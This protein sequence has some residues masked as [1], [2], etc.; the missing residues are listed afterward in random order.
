M[1]K[2]SKILISCVA[3]LLVLSVGYA[4]FS[5]NITI[6]GTATAEGDFS[7]D[8]VAQIGV[9]SELDGEYVNGDGNPVDTSSYASSG[10][11]IESSINCTDNKVTYSGNFKYP[12]Q[13]QYFSVKLTNTGSIPI[14]WDDLF[15]TD[16]DSN[17][18][19]NLIM[20]D[21][22]MVDING[23]WPNAAELRS[24]YGLEFNSE[25]TKFTGSMIDVADVWVSKRIFDELE[26]N[27]DAQLSLKNGESIYYIFCAQWPDVNL[28]PYYVGANITATSTYKFTIKQVTN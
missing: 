7:F 12:G 19:G 3:L 18:T 16:Y 26:L 15:K 22:E 9:P 1:N 11:N 25:F 10:A 20:R 6:N 8:V 17:A 24:K 23:N 2:K 14:S 28:N 5:Q 27:P 13:K 4:L 21:G